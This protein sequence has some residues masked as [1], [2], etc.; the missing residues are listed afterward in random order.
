MSNMSNMFKPNY[1]PDVLNFRYIHIMFPFFGSLVAMP[2]HAIQCHS[3]PC[4]AMM[5]RERQLHKLKKRH[6]TPL[7][8]NPRPQ[9]SI[10]PNSNRLYIGLGKRSRD[11]AVNG[12]ALAKGVLGHLGTIQNFIFS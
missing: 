3:M 7:K 10:N 11:H 5:L 4:D 9:Q 12:R 1:L 6:A 2:C 8:C